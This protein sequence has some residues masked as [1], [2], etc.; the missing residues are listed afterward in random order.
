MSPSLRTLSER[1]SS[2]DGSTYR[3]GS[4]LLSDRSAAFR[5]GVRAILNLYN[6]YNSANFVAST[7][8]TSSEQTL[9]IAVSQQP[10][11]ILLDSH[12]AGSWERTLNLL[13]QL[14]QLAPALN[15]LLTADYL[16]PQVI[17]EGMQAGATGC[18]TRDNVATELFTAIDTILSNKIYL[19][20]TALK[21]FFML[22]QVQ[23]RD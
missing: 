4:I 1:L 7:E 21:D 20:E 11:L 8:A 14:Q 22:F 13:I 3:E 19:S 6:H 2:T 5:L 18:I 9:N 10:S 17:F 16:E 15:I 23:A 12:L